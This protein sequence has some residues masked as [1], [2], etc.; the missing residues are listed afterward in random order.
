MLIYEL[1][2]DAEVSREMCGFCDIP[3]TGTTAYFQRIHGDLPHALHIPG[4]PNAWTV[5][6]DVVPL[7]EQG[8]HLMIMPN[9][10]WI[11]LATVDDQEGLAATTD[12]VISGLRKFFF[13]SHILF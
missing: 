2:S 5:L 13:Q 6:Q 11:S 9:R 10:H 4:I 12:R 7:A 3:Q 1:P 8:G